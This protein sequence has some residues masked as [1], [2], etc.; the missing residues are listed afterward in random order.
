MSPDKLTWTLTGATVAGVLAVYVPCAPRTVPGGDSGELLTAACELGVAH[1][2]GYPL[3]TMLSSLMLSLL[4]LSSPTHS[5]NVL[6]AVFGAGASGALCFTVCRVSGPGPGAVLAGGVFA[7]SRLVWQWSVMAE[8]F[9]LNNLFVGV[10]FTL[11]ACFHCAES[12]HQKKK[13]ALWGALCCG[14]SLCNQ[15]TLVLYVAVIISWAILHLYTHNGL[16]FYGLLSLGTCF[17]A[18]FMPYI[19]LPISSYLNR[20]R[21]SWG[22]QTSLSGLLTHLIRAEYG[23]FSLAK[24]EESVAFMKMLQAQWNHCVNDL[25]TPV[26]VL[27]VLSVLFSLRNRG[28]FVFV[29]LILI[30]VSIYSMFFAWRANLDI[31]KPL[32][33]GVV[34]RFWLQADAGVCVLAGLGLSWT[35]CWLN[36][37]LG[38]G[39]VWN[40][41]AW[42]LTVGLISYMIN[43]NHRECDQSSN[44][45]VDRFAREVVFSLPEGS[46]VLTRGDLPGNTLRYLHYCQGLRPDL[47]LVDQEMMTYGWYV[48]KLQKHLPRVKFP[49][50]R[51]DPVNSA[52]KKTFSIAQFL[53]HNTHRPVFVC[54]G[55]NEGDPSWE[56]SFSRW[57]WGVCEQLVPVKTPFEPEKWAHRTL[58]L[59]NWS[60]PHDSFHPGS[61]ERVANDEMW[62]ARM[63]TAFFLFDLA[64][65]M[66]GEAQARLYEISYNLYCQIVDAQVYYPANW[67]KNL[68]LAAERLLRSG[69][70]SSSPD[71]LL[72]CS[73]LHF[74]RYLQREPTDPQR[75]AIRSTISHLRK[76]RDRLR[77]RQKG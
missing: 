18:G 67:D 15:H 42:I 32:L 28:R 77:G 50:G 19:Y 46:L 34:E 56:R 69:G 25:S 37:R 45:V 74:T 24:T 2:P 54:I 72:S 52:E 66:E 39:A 22:D 16:S 70:G 30:M 58:N 33:L 29:W 26:L 51:W 8:V 64:E 62:Q 5:I 20:A 63:K 43:L 1:P 10:L 4:P 9:A 14:L 27:V 13:Y 47:S 17:L 21:W 55:L 53:K 75:K 36:R 71:T 11:S 12:V 38:W 41:G 23:T 3:F 76:E 7:V 61:W 73:I 6:C 57:P 31:E 68:A 59:Y 35:L 40:T 44:D 48:A 60:Q 65:K 49:G